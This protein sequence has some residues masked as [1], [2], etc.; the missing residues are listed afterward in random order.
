MEKET[1]ILFGK[2]LGEIY[3]LQGDDCEICEGTIYGLK[4]GFE[5]VLDDIIKDYKITNDDYNNFVAILNPI[6]NDIDKLKNF[7]GYYDI[8]DQMINVGIDRDKAIQLFTYFK[9][10]GKFIKLIDKLDSFN[11]PCELTT[12]E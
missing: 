1:K 7:T 10:S 12:F 3:Q 11:S 4:N 5:F 8:E 2:I 6:F 9:K